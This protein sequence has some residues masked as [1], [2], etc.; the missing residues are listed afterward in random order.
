V[1][2]QQMRVAIFADIYTPSWET[3]DTGELVL[4]LQ[5]LGHECDILAVLGAQQSAAPGKFPVTYLSPKNIHDYKFWSSTPYDLVICYTWLRAKY[6]PLLGAIKRSGKKVIV[7]GDSDGR[8]NFPVNPRWG[9]DIVPPISAASARI[10][11][12]KLKRWLWAN[13]YLQDLVTHIEM[14]DRLVVESPGAY[15]N[16]SGIL[17]YAKR[18]D[19][20]SKISSIQNPVGN[21][22]LTRSISSKKR[23]VVC[24]GEWTRVV[25]EALQKN[26]DCMIDVIAEFLKIEPEYEVTVIGNMGGLEKRFKRLDEFQRNRLHLLGKVSHHDML[27]HL[28]KAQV[29]F[30][31]SMTEGF[32]IAASEAV[33]LGCSIVGTPLECLIYLARGGVGGTIAYD[34]RTNA[35][36]GALLADINRWKRGSYEAVEI[37]EF[38][39][40]RLSP[41]IISQLMLDSVFSH[42]HL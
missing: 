33:A 35:V 24:V 5:E 27:S 3:K 38:W 13:T 14:I 37:S 21:S 22:A 6:L 29:F 16:I 17:A 15:S 28:E 25:G 11:L 26:T 12:R 8:Y 42:D 41:K 39:R 2:E 7:K 19:L 9:Q 34:F 30:M 36:L 32:S 18:P 31:P 1:K 4:G 10:I 40:S 20:V 23:M